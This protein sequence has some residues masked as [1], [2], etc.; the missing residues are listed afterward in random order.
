[1][2][3]SIVHIVHGYM[4]GPGDHWFGWLKGQVERAGGSARILAMP[5]SE[6]PD[7]AAWDRTLVDE[8]GT[9][10][11][12]TF[13]VAHSLGTVASMRYLQARPEA[14][15]GGLILVSAFDSR[16]A[17]IPELDGFMDWKPI[18][19]DT[20]RRVA[21]NR[22]VVTATNDEVVAPHLSIALAGALEADLI[23]MD[24]GGHFLGSEGHDTFPQVWQ[25]LT[26][27]AAAR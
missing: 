14:R 6:N 16:L 27:Q 4:A 5:D 18:A 9:P 19:H 12:N 22:A 21:T 25:K 11:Q 15:V 26:E 10:D 8:I 13:I 3:G 7:P 1:M 23:A 24:R 2:D 17:N 20:I